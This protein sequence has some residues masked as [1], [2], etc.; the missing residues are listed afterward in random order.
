MSATRRDRLTA[1]LPM[2]TPPH[3]EGGVGALR[4]EVR[5]WRN[6][7]RHV[8][9]VGI[10]DRVAHVA[11][12]VAAAAARRLIAGDFAAGVRVLGDTGSP[13]TDVLG[14]LVVDGLHLHEFVGSAQE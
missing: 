8:E 13:N 3:A 14:D 2:L 5:G 12:L 10:A 6:A 1:R 4:I 9:V 11:G 7:A